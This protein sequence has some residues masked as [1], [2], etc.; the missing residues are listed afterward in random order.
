MPGPI[1]V[2]D[3]IRRC[4]AGDRRPVKAV[5]FMQK[6]GSASRPV[7]V[8]CDD[9]SVYVIKGAHNMRTLVSEHVVGRLGQL[10]DAP[11]GE[12]CFGEITDEF[13]A[14]EPQLGDVAAGIGHATRWVPNCSD[15][16]GIDQMHHAYNRQRFARL[17]VLYS[18]AL[19]GDHQLIYSKVDPFV[20]Y[21]VDH[22]HF[23]HGTTGW[24]AA[25]LRQVG[26]VM[27]D[28]FFTMCGLPDTA[29][30]DAKEALERVTEEE[31]HDITLGPPGAWG[32]TAD[33]RAAL[34]EYLLARRLALAALLP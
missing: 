23:L 29:L 26:P 31:I 18:W 16:A 2:R 11:V 15:R 7:V 21:S 22:G 12:V 33:D 19:A 8:T 6:Y 25:S 5:T 30:H 17:Q 24:S 10:M 13:K 27:L 4:A 32:V 1:E 28:P 14:I 9:G 3:A 20:V 34:K